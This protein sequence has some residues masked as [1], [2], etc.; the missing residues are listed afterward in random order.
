MEKRKKDKKIRPLKIKALKWWIKVKKTCNKKSNNTCQY[1]DITQ[2]PYNRQEECPNLKKYC[3]LPES[4]KHSNTRQVSKS[5]I[6]AHI[7]ALAGIAGIITGQINPKCIEYYQS[8]R[9]YLVGC[10]RRFLA[11]YRRRQRGCGWQT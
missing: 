6:F 11:H 8:L 9:L 4:N 5:K 10:G 2:C 3:H 1:K 7:L